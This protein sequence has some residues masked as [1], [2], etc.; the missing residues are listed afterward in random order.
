MFLCFLDMF[1]IKKVN[2]IL[3]VLFVSFI[4]LVIV[5]FRKSENQ[6]GGSILPYWN[7]MLS[8]KVSSQRQPAR[9]DLRKRWYENMQEIYRR[10]PM[11]KCDFNKVALQ[12]FQHWLRNSWH[13]MNL[14]WYAPKILFSFH[15]LSSCFLLLRFR[16][17]SNRS[18]N[19]IN[20]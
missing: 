2:L 1:L 16:L 7:N 8:L 3:V 13:F 20:L 12:L 5:S 6:N 18:S 14:I 19:D 15:K 10:T 17:N 4:F 9:G 11:S